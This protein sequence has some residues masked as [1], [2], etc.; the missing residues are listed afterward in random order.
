MSF[1]ELLGSGLVLMD[2]G[3]GTQLCAMGLGA[4][5]HS[6]TWNLTHPQEVASVHRAY[7]DA[8]SNILTA[9]TFNVNTLT[10]SK[11]QADAM[12]GAAFEN[13]RRAKAE[14]T[15]TQ[16][17]L[18]ALDIG[19]LGRL[20][21]PFGDLSFEDAR[22]AFADVVS[23]GVKHGAQVVLIETFTDLR[24]TKA[25]LLAVKETCS[26]PVIVS[27]AY[28]KDRRLLT[29]AEPEAVI[30]M[31]E[32][33]GADAIGLNCSFGPETLAPIAEVYLSHTNLPILF[34]PNAGL[35]ENTPD[36]VRYSVDPESFAASVTEMIRKGVQLAGGCCGT[37]PA[38]IRRLR[39][40]SDGVCSIRPKAK[41]R[42]VITSRVAAFDL[43]DDPAELGAF[44]GNA[45][46]K[47]M[48]SAFENGDL[49][50]VLTEA[51]TQEESG[52]RI[53]TVDAGSCGGKTVLADAVT[54]L[55]TDF[56]LP[57]QF[58]ADDPAALETA[59]RVY[60]GKA[61]VRLADGNRERLQSVFPLI[62]KYGGTAVVSLPEKT[63]NCLAAAEEILREA[64]LCKI[65]KWDLIFVLQNGE[66]ETA[67]TIK[68]RLGCRTA[69]L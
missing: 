13:L 57:L 9:N 11:E 62:V 47:E 66:A 20:L 14:T 41:A 59:L 18:F 44:L 4:G 25:A 17:I 53:L 52:A 61:L 8:G 39:E 6:E 28:S 26:L 56:T 5:E 23:L 60:I 21:E 42:A 63:E 15:G 33:M 32:G 10:Y 36:G 48:Q 50:A 49:D 1:S 64:E 65:A 38:Y 69:I 68:S 46:C 7:M 24:E 58:A 54:E 3:M 30:A 12:I 55:Q 29:G 19:P 43:G 51:E 16:E 40:E 27:N 67:A 2:G 35:P 45:F 37:T 31:L 34:Q 22:S